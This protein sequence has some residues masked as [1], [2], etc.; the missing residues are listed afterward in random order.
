MAYRIRKLDP[1]WLGAPFV[2]AAALAAGAAAALAAQSG[3]T[4]L[5]LAAAA[6]CGVGVLISTKPALS[7][8]FA[9]FGLL[10]GAVTFLAS[11]GG[12]LAPGARALATAGFSVFY[13]ALMDC[14]VLGVS[15]AYNLFTRA[16]FRGVALDLERPV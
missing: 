10:G 9:V 7:G 5:A 8:V 3:R 15:L 11:P 1:F 14:V 16:G 4:P 12:G 6:A 2:P 13:M